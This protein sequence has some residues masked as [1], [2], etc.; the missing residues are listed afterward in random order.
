MTKATK[1]F[2]VFVTKIISVSANGLAQV[3]IDDATFGSVIG[4]DSAVK[5]VATAE[6]GRNVTEKRFE[7]DGVVFFSRYQYWKDEGAYSS[8]FYMN[9]KDA[10]ARLNTS[11]VS[12][13]ASMI[14]DLSSFVAEAVA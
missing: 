4:K 8:H 2:S 10:Q 7:I 6:L 11:G 3:K 5:P 1:A 9:V 12:G 13:K 14:G